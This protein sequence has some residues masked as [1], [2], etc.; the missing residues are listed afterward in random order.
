MKNKSEPIID[1]VTLFMTDK[2]KNE[3]WV[4][5]YARM[6]EKGLSPS[7]IFKPVYLMTTK[8]HELG[9]LRYINRT[10]P[11]TVEETNYE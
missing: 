7:M 1:D 9:G 4:I 11:P 5:H 8:E 6:L 10:A 2:Q 3:L